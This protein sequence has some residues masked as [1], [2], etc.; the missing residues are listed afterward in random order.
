MFDYLE[1]V[2]RAAKFNRELKK[3]KSQASEFWQE[4]SVASPLS[5]AG[6]KRL[7]KKIDCRIPLALEE[8]YTKGSAA[9]ACRY[10]WEVKG[11]ARREIEKLFY[12]N[13][14]IY[15]GAQLC[16]AT[17]LPEEFKLHREFAHLYYQPE[18]ALPF[19]HIEN[20][21][22]LALD[23]STASE[24]PPVFYLCLSGDNNVIA[25][26]FTEFLD[27]WEK[28]FY[29]GPEFWLL[30]VFRNR[31]GLLTAKSKKAQQLRALFD[32]T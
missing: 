4:T 24:N 21:D 11:K 6:L 23:L 14:A 20:G 3:T 22:T 31:K 28:L 13:D 29:I 18:T 1:W 26:S 17:E 19:C 10:Y 7:Q 25:E 5:A 15:G 16:S 2:Q 30:D 27:T 8:F 32:M 9:C 12:G